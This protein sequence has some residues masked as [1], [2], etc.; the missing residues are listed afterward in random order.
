MTTPDHPPPGGPLDEYN[1]VA[2]TVGL[3]PSLRARDHLY[4]GL[5]AMGGAIGGFLAGVGLSLT[6]VLSV[7][8]VYGGLIGAM[9]GLIGGV[10]VSG[11][12]LMIAGFVRARRGKR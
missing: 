11:F 10:F 4:Q 12:A 1:K 5:S 8:W 7:A 9:L 3:M 2:E 6:G